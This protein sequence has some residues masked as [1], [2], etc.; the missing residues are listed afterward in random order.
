MQIIV[1]SQWVMQEKLL[2]YTYTE[3]SAFEALVL[4]VQKKINTHTHTKQIKKKQLHQTKSDKT[5]CLLF[6]LFNFLKTN[7]WAAYFLY[8]TEA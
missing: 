6:A 3:D 4:L 1:V 5:G 7:P 2:S 8:L